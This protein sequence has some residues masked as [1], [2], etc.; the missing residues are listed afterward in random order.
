[1]KS[2]PFTTE[3]MNKRLLWTTAALLTTALGIPLCSQ[4]EPIKAV[5]PS[6]VNTQAMSPDI[7]PPAQPIDVVKVGEYQSQ[8]KTKATE[9]VIARI[10]P[11]ELAGRQVVTLYVRNIPVLTFFGSNPVTTSST[12][13]GAAGNGT[14]A[15][16]SSQTKV[17]SIGTLADLSNQVR[18][19]ID[20]FQAT[21]APVWRATAVAAKLNQLN[22]DKVDASKITA[23]WK[24][25]GDSANPTRGERYLIKVN[26]EELVEINPE[27]RLPDQTKNLAQDA[28]QVTNR[29]RRLLGNAAPLREISGLPLPL[30]KLPQQISLGSV[31]I[32][33]SGW[34][35]WYGPGFHGNRSASGE[36]YN[37]N[38]LT[39]AHRSLP[40]GTKVRV[41]NT[42]TGSSVV[43]RINDRGPYIGGRII[44]LSAAAARIL[45]VMKTGV[46]PVRVEVLSN[47][48]RE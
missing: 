39:A 35:S 21:N 45:G 46:A 32:R 4:A 27:T 9:T 5:N 29:L 17:A 44:D 14:S 30:P 28:L 8:T 36:I 24:A 41:I 33:L 10:Q 16:R 7:M 26:G 31:R 2:D 37:Q 3:R 42:R 11:H 25:G 40:F 23:V 20:N 34:A 38:A 18:G 19:G 13:V 43:V 12:K 1:M 22:L 47:Q 48:R 15:N 6:R